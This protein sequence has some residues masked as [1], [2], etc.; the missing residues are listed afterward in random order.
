MLRLHILAGLV[1][2]VAG[3]VAMAAEK[4]GGRHRQAGMVFVYSMLIMSA[5]GALLAMVTPARMNVIT[6]VLTF[7]LVGT[8]LL[9]VRRPVHEAR[10][11]NAGFMLLA[12]AV[13]SFSFRFGFAASANAGG[14]VDGVPAALYFM[15]GAVALVAALL[16][17]RMLLADGIQGADRLARHLW[18]MGFAMLIATASFFLERA[19]VFPP[20]LR[21]SGLLLIPVMLVIGFLLYWVV[22]VRGR[23]R[24]VSL[25]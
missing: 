12:L 17:G 25:D 20:L 18:R 15:L 23:R 22:R 19:T 13:A 24:Q 10:A 21:K 6:S 5:S 7:Y 14:R 8:A 1:A 4:G 9:T 2:L 3:A 16:D 11:W